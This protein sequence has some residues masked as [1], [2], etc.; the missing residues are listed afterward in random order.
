MKP[1]GVKSPEYFGMICFVIVPVES[2]FANCK[3]SLDCEGVFLVDGSSSEVFVNVV[4][5]W[6]D[7]GGVWCPLGKE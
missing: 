3:G 1:T 4:H 6:Y 5:R 7:S 2:L